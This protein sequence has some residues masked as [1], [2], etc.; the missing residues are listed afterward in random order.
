MSLLDFRQ[1]VLMCA[2]QVASEEKVTLRYLNCTTCKMVLLTNRG[3]G[4]KVGVGSLR[5]ADNNIYIKVLRSSRFWST[6]AH[7]DGV[8][9]LLHEYVVHWRAN[10][11]I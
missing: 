5:T 8:Y 10:N 1:R 11:L 6:Q 4:G 3:D 7:T 9:I 2:D